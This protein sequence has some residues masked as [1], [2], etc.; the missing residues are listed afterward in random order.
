MNYLNYCL[1]LSSTHTQEHVQ[2]GEYDM[3]LSCFEKVLE[4]Q[5]E[6]HGPSHP[7]VASAHHN[8]G[9]LHA[10]RA[11]LVLDE[12]A[13][14]RHLRA[15]ALASFQA[16]ART[17]RDALG[18]THPNVAVS[19]VRIG[20]LLLQSRQYQN[21]IVTFKEALRIRLASLGAHDALVANLYNN[22]GVCHMHLGN[23][24]QGYEYLEAAMD[25]QR[26]F[27]NEKLELAD[28]LFNIGG[29]CLEWIRRQGPDLRRAVDAEEAFAEALELR[30]R[31]L[32]P[33]HPMVIQ[34]KA[35]LDMAR[36]V[37]RPTKSFSDPNERSR[38]G[39]R[40]YSTESHSTR[41]E[42]RT[43]PSH[44]TSSLVEPPKLHRTT[45]VA[46]TLRATRPVE[47]QIPA[48]SQAPD[49]FRAPKTTPPRHPNSS[50][51]R[52]SL[53]N[54][55]DVETATKIYVA[56]HLIP[57]S[58][59][60]RNIRL[61]DRL[62]SPDVSATKK[63]QSYDAEE[64]VL[65]SD[66]GI[67]SENGRIHYPLAWNK[68]RIASNDDDDEQYGGRA[69]MVTQPFRTH[70][71]K[72]AFSTGN[73]E[74]DSIMN[75]AKALLDAQSEISVDDTYGSPDTTNMMTSSSK[76]QEV[77]NMKILQS[78]T[79]DQDLL[80]DGLSPLGGDWPHSSKR[81]MSLRELLNDP[82]NNL[83]LIH[84]E[85]ARRLQNDQ[86]ADAL[87]LFTT[88]LS[89]QRQRHGNT[90]PDVASSLHNVGIAQL[91]QPNYK[92]ALKAFDE[93][94]R[95]RKS[96]LG[97]DH[98]QVAVRT[99]PIKDHLSFPPQTLISTKIIY[100]FLGISCEGRDYSFADASIR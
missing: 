4:L 67:D 15:L 40:E 99:V 88:I 14:Q 74:R 36:A 22:L 97:R 61:T 90:H 87:L 77:N 37:P 27:T 7:A 68:A 86:V 58:S 47:K 56:P 1:T 20:F 59:P 84:D 39:S 23:F 82:T 81:D 38:R 72:D 6:H 42:P 95:I 28:T 3:A 45:G 92:E 10:K 76:Q 100:T 16:A 17:A 65:I 51:I 25:I 18:K 78:N 55:R 75:R 53:S 26:D 80:E 49:I 8:L 32:G 57:K 24:E 34:V 93:S 79:F 9:T 35:L 73:K 43:S 66:T 98:P 33:D 12:S 46:S 94:A 30:T 21:A 85:A 50:I 5:I 96:A 44:S 13:Q 48:Q 11:A 70:R 29:L 71:E 91:R 19:L 54:D 63:V 41:S 60:S 31:V 64:S 89:C 62:P 69:I 83:H 52:S 2:N